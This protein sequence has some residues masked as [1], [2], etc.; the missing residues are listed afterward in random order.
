MVELICLDIDGTLV[1]SNKELPEANKEAVQYALSRGVKVAIASGRSRKGVCDILKKLGIPENAIC[2]NGGL[3][4]WD[5]E[6]VREKTMEDELVYRVIDL[7]EKYQTCLFVST[8]GENITNE[9]ITPELQK[10]IEQG[11][12]RS[13][14]CY[15]R[16]FDELRR[17]TEKRSGKI[18]K[19]GIQEF[20]PNRFKELK[21]ELIRMDL[22]QIA[23]SDKYFVDINLKN[24]G[25]EVGI[26]ALADYLDIPMEHV[27]CIGDNENDEKMIQ[28][29]GVGVAMKNGTDRLRKDADYVTASNDDAGVAQAIYRSL[30]IVNPVLPGFHPDPCICKAE[31]K[32]YLITSTFEWIPG[33]SLYESEDLVNWKPRGGILNKLNLEGIPD[34]A[35]IWAPALTWDHGRFYLIYTI[36]RQIDGYFKDVSNYV[37]TAE[38]IDGPWSEPIFINASGF[39]PSMYHENGRHYVINPQWDPRPLPG[40]QK[41][42]GLIMQ[43]FDFEKGMVG[44]AKV[45]YRGSGWGSAEG[46]H[47]MK[48]GKYYYILAAEGG[49]GRHHSVC[50]ARSENLWGPYEVSP[51]TPLITAWEKDTILKKSG[52]GNLVETDDGEWYLVHL[53][54]RYLDKY[55]VCPL[56]RETSIQKVVWVDDWPVLAGGDNTPQ[57]FVP[58][59]RG[60]VQKTSGKPDYEIEFTDRIS[61]E[62]LEKQ[63]WLSLR[64]P[65]EQKA[66]FTAEGLQ[67]Q[68]GDSL[69]S[70][71]DQ[72]MI[73]RRWESFS[74]EAGTEL[75][76]EPYHYA[77]TAGLTCYYNTKVFYYL[78]VGYDEKTGRRIVN[79]LKN[80][81][82]DFSEPLNGTCVEVPEST[83]TIHL[84]VRVYQDQLQFFCS[85]DGENFLKVGEKLDCSILS[86]EH[87]P[88]WSYTGSVVGITA[89]DTFNKDTYAVFRRFYQREQKGNMK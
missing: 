54:G 28:E 50:A 32:Y 49:T 46:P 22:F 39:D 61:A 7:A 55:P 3:I 24:M 80:D 34:S 43:E 2:L 40:H 20:H 65:L 53:C 38:S 8:A 62:M 18:I 1:D 84:K 27:M 21:Q 70:L 9:T 30:G 88:G 44:E 86:D 19:M 6:V 17:E 51:Y 69:T 77:Q 73:A 67:L 35:G 64:T 11:S 4:V 23:R 47:L 37:T 83:E 26:R 75:K 66:S 48:R 68:G 33:V 15:C 87:A 78:Y 10:L 14:Y 31:G 52:H 16:D 79:I 74:F 45:V 29:A 36:C 13:G 59:P 71:F 5:G 25:K 12:L 89:V 57:V 63:E 56:G 60:A 85:F 42:N 82:L 72:S 41:F 81:N 76:F 58:A